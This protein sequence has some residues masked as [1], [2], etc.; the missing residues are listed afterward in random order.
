VKT[1][2]KNTGYF[3]ER[4]NVVHIFI[5]VAAALVSEVLIALLAA[6]YLHHCSE[7]TDAA[8]SKTIALSAEGSART[9]PAVQGIPQGRQS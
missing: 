2:L 7:Q 1:A 9:E 3:A 4:I 5:I 8:Q 6:R